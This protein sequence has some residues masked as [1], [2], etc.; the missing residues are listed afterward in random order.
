VKFSKELSNAR[1]SHLFGKEKS[2]AEIL[3][4]V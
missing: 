3:G 4:A 1:V 2:V